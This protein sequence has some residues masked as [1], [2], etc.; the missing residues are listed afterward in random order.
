MT[1]PKWWA[2]FSPDE[3]LP[4]KGLEFKIDTL[5]PD[6]LVLRLTGLTGRTKKEGGINGRR[7][8]YGFTT[9]TTPRP[10][11]GTTTATDPPARGETTTA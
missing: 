7:K 8:T 2:L 11:E 4:W 3:L 9:D 5:H 6:G 1:A 10:A